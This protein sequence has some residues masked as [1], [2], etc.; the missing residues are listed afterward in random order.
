MR[1]ALALC[2]LLAPLAAQEEFLLGAGPYPDGFEMRW[3]GDRADARLRFAG[4][5]VEALGCALAWIDG[6]ARLGGVDA[7]ARRVYSDGENKDLLRLYDGFAGFARRGHDRWVL[8]GIGAP[9]RPTLVLLAASSESGEG[10]LRIG[11]EGPVRRFVCAPDELADEAALTRL[12]EDALA[13]PLARPGFLHLGP[14]ALVVGAGEDLVFR[15]RAPW[16]VLEPRAATS[17][18]AGLWRLERGTWRQLA[19]G[20][21]EALVD[22]H[23]SPSAAEV[24]RWLAFGL[25]AAPGSFTVQDPLLWMLEEPR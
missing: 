7:N 14:R 11:P 5:R 1:Y 8:C 19:R 18:G 9:A 22:L 15:L 12:L 25:D 20:A 23:Q 17:A 10:E 4:R 13:L 3:S 21:P 2:L 24:S 16:D 6:H